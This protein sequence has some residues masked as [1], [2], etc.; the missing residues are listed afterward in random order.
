MKVH[1]NGIDLAYSDEGEG[2]PIVF[3]HAF[4]LNRTMWVPQ[5]EVL[6]DHYRI[7][8]IDLRGHGESD[9]PMWRYTL[10]QFADDSIALLQHL[11]IPQATIVGLSMGG[12][13]LF[14]LYQK[15]PEFVR[16]LVLADTRAQADTP[17]GKA[18]RFSMAQV[19]YRRGASAIAELMLPKLLSPSGMERHKNLVTKLRNIITG[20]QTAGIIGD[21]MAMEERPDFTPL[22]QTIN[23]PT[24]VLVGEY[25]I[26]SPPTEMKKMAEQIPGAKLTVIPQAGHVSN[27]ENPEAFNQALFKFLRKLGEH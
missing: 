21:L 25:D 24:L 23:V 16:A 3:L 10:E 5:V 8:T 7:I 11:A 12:Y 22:A 19:A 9:A 27:L 17:E 20:N 4:P 26:P 2:H 6:K 14:T 13:I 18:T 1:V 15:Y